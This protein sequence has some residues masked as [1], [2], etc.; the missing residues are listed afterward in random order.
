MPKVSVLKIKLTIN[1]EAELTERE[2]SILD[3]VSNMDV[4]NH[5]RVFIFDEIKI[6]KPT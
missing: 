5:F 1:M 2:K 4:K 3:N 6:L